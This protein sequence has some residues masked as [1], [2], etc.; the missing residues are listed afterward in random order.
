MSAQFVQFRATLGRS[1]A[2][3]GRMP[4]V[5]FGLNFVVR[6]KQGQI[7]Q[8]SAQNWPTPACIWSIPSGVGRI[9]RVRPQIGRA[10][11]RIGLFRPNSIHQSRSNS[12]Q[13]RRCEPSLAEFIRS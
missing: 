7:W 10:R 12:A 11:P 13:I 1:L 2:K 5:A 4:S 6:S 3:F 9:G 8:N